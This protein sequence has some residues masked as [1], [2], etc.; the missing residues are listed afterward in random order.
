MSRQLHHR[1]VEATGSG[2][3][4][5]GAALWSSKASEGATRADILAL[6]DK[7]PAIGIS[8]RWSFL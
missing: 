3:L 2:C 1:R 5:E 8:R 4:D 6:D 7:L